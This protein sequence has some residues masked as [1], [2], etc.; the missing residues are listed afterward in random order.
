MKSILLIA[1]TFFIITGCTP[2]NEPQQGNVMG[3]VPV[4]AQTTS[5]LNH[6]ILPQRATSKAGKIYAFGNFLFQNDIGTGIHIINNTNRTSPQKVGFIELPLSTELAVKGNFLYC[7]NYRDIVVFNITNPATPQMVKRMSNVFPAL[8]QQYPPYNNCSFE[9][10]DPNK[11]VVI[12]WE[13]KQITN[14][15]CRR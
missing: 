4:Y 15:K 5:V 7:N 10:V 13:E 12:Y 9:C 3:Y 8:N 14:P 2:E 1:F 6:R 11:G